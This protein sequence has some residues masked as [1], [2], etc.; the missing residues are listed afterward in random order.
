MPHLDGLSS[1]GVIRKELKRSEADLP[2]IGISATH[3]AE[4]IQ[5]YRNV[6]MNTF[7]AKP[8]TEKMLL[9]VMSSLTKAGA[10][11]PELSEIKEES[12][13]DQDIDLSDLYH[14]ANH[15]KPFI[16]VLLVQF[17][18]STERG[19]L[20]IKESIENGEYTKAAEIAH[21]ISAPCKHV[22]AKLLYSYMKSIEKL[23]GQD[24][25]L[26]ELKKLYSDSNKEFEILK[27][28]LQAHLMK[29]SEQ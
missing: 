23:N 6:G 21:K 13:P 20:E 28:I 22:G 26:V 7:L 10:V 16:R 18:E 11:E 9:D 14:M 17:I 19:L 12:V 5:K 3:T 2:V 29:M 15:D 8:F 4:D 1:T 24:N 27:N 25:G